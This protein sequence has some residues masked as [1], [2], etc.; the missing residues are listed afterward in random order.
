[1]VRN[2]DPAILR[3]H[4]SG[5]WEEAFRFPTPNLPSEGVLDP[6]TNRLYMT[7]LSC[8][9]SYLDGE[10]TEIGSL[11]PGFEIFSTIP[12]ICPGNLALDAGRGILYTPLYTNP[13]INHDGACP[14]LTDVVGVCLPK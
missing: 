4:K 2:E 13:C 8:T 14:R 1:M 6:L 12:S 9:L 11:G 10:V 7:D 3:S 5:G